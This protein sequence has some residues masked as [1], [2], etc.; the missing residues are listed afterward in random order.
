MNLTRKDIL[1]LIAIVV[2][3]LVA[4]VWALYGT[5]LWHAA[6]PDRDCGIGTGRE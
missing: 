2:V 3:G 1:I 6:M 4:V 5:P